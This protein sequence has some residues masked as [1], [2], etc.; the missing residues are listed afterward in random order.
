MFPLSDDNPTLAVG[1]TVSLGE[2]ATCRIAGGAVRYWTP[3]T[4]MFLH[5]SWG[6]LIGNGWF[7]WVVLYPRV[8][9]RTLIFIVIIIRIIEIPA[10]MMLVYWFVLQLVTALPQLGGKAAS[11]GVAVVA[12]VGGF[13]A[14]CLLVR[15]FKNP[16]RI[17]ART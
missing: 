5:G 3:L 12:H 9:V 15:T 14:G 8:R 4:S 2:T 10:W 1:T 17:K 11:S 13:L 7:L 16:A 6:H